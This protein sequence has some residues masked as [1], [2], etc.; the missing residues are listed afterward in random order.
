[1]STWT[2]KMHARA[3]EAT[4]IY[5]PDSLHKAFLFHVLDEIE[6]LRAENTNLLAE[7]ER[8][9]ALTTVDEDM[10]EPVLKH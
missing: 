9:R 8:L 10:V 4:E 6:R 5:Y 1:M 3:R 2:D 7:V